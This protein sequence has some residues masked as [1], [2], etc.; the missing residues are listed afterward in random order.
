MLR[1]ICTLCLY[2]S[3]RGRAIAGRGHT[4]LK[5]STRAWV[6][7]VSLA[8]IPLLI[9]F[10]VVQ[11]EDAALWVALAGAVLNTG[12]ATANTSTS[13]GSA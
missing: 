5:E 9:A 13:S 7:R 3:T 8:V 11:N 6:Y 12:L 1:E 2:V 4:M 10:G